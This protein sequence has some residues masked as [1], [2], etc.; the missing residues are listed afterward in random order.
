MTNYVYSDGKGHNI[1]VKENVPVMY[2]QY[3][4]DHGYELCSI[5]RG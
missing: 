5:T 3:L 4:A 1:I 2:A